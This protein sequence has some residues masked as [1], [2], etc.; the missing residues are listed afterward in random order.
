MLRSKKFNKIS[1]KNSKPSNNKSQPTSLRSKINNSKSKNKNLNSKKLSKNFNILCFKSN[2]FSTLK[3]TFKNHKKKLK[4]FRSNKTQ[5]LKLRKMT[6]RMTGI[7]THFCRLK[8]VKILHMT[9]KISSWDSWGILK[10]IKNG[11]LELQGCC[12]M[13]V[14]RSWK[15]LLSSRREIGMTNRVLENSSSAPH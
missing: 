5:I 8:S 4:S 2:H 12:Q 10:R 14:F 9:H 11:I 13:T 6:Q 15:L 1:T 7:S 3:T